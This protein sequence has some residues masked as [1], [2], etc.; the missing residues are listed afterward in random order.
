MPGTGAILYG[1]PVEWGHPLNRGLAAWW[2]AVPGRG[3]GCL[4]DLAGRCPPA[5]RVNAPPWAAMPNGFHWL[6]LTAASDQYANCGNPPAL[7]IT[8]QLTVAVRYKLR[9]T[10][11]YLNSYQLFSKDADSGGRA[12]TLDLSLG[13]LPVNSGVRF[14]VDGGS[15][16]NI[17]VEGR[18]VVAGD[19]RWVCG[20]FTPSTPGGLKLYVD[21]VLTTSSGGTTGASIPTASTSALIGRRGYAGYTEPLNGWV[22]D[23]RVYSR[24]LAADEVAEL[25][26]QHR[27]GYPDLLRRVTRRIMGLVP[28]SASAADLLES[29]HMPGFGW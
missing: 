2:L 11:A 26:R 1:Q 24:A 16:G 10:P 25:Y 29:V 8:G 3:G 19:N 5:A 23:V 7:Q 22:G 4:P 12:Y 21:G 14:Y 15:S 28:A 17:V 13:N 20:T 18:D 9:T 6:D 27:R